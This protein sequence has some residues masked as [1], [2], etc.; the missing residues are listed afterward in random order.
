MAK[1]KVVKVDEEMLKDNPE[2]AEAGVKV[3]D[4]G[5][6][7][8]EVTVSWRGGKRTYSLKVHGE[9]FMALAKEFCTKKDGTVSIA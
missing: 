4:E 9:D 6:E 1:K 2:L 8:E 5:I 7:T 3:G